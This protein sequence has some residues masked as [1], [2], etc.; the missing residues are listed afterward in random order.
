MPVKAPA[1]PVPAAVGYDWSGFHIGA[2]VGG[3][4][5]RKE[6]FDP[7]AAVHNGAHHAVG[8]L[9]GG[10]IGFSHQ[11]ARWV[12]GVEAQVSAAN[13]KGANVDP[14]NLRVTIST[15]VDWLGSVAGRLGYA[16]DRTLLFVKAGG[17]FVHDKH[18]ATGVDPG[19]ASVGIAN[20]TR[21]GWIAGGGIEHALASNWSVKMEYNYMD[22]GTK[23][24]TFNIAGA[25][26]APEDVTQHI[27]LVK[28]GINYRFGF[29]R[30]PAPY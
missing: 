26:P 28:F 23:R 20:E 25:A 8:I 11:V 2:H 24:L 30:L 1:M 14:T 19:N 27:H 18:V 12:M 16:S 13:L 17:A 10:Q 29:A 7:L 4:W 15:R 3:G 6:F 9:G 5:G 21:W 22:F